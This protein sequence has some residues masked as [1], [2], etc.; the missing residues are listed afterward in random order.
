MG[1][2]ESK[3]MRAGNGKVVGGPDEGPAPASASGLQASPK[4]SLDSVP[5][6]SRDARAGHAGVLIFVSAS[7]GCLRVN[8]IPK[9]DALC[10]PKH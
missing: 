4:K 3:E 1:A 8:Q 2:E 10:A 7:F 9:A 6:H 5:Q